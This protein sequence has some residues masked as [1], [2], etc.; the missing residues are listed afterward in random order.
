MRWEEF[1][2][3]GVV[4]PRWI[5]NTRLWWTRQS[6]H[7][8]EVRVADVEGTVLHTVTFSAITSAVS[9]ELA[10][11]VD[12]DHVVLS[13]LAVTLDPLSLTFDLAGRSWAYDPAT[14]TVAERPTGAVAGLD[15]SPDGTQAVLLREHD[16]WLRDMD[17]GV[18]RRLTR[19]GSSTYS[20][21]APCAARRE[22]ALPD[23]KPEGLWSPDSR[24]YFTLQADDRHVPELS[25][26]DFVPAAGGRP[27][28]LGN[29][30]SLPADPKV[31]EFR[32]LVLDVASGRQVEARHPRLS[33]VRMNDTV[34][35]GGMVWWSTDSNTAW[36]VDIERGERAAHVVAMDSTTGS[37]RTVMTER[38]DVPLEL[39]VNVYTPALICPLPETN[40]LVWYSE[41]SG[42]GHLYL[43][44]L[45]S[46]QWKR[47]IT[48]GEW[49]VRDVLGVD[50]ARREVALLAGGLD[51]SNPYLRRPCIASL[52]TDRLTVLS[53]TAGDHQV[54]R[55]R[56]F[57][58]I[59]AQL[60]EGV[61]VERVSGFSPDGE[62]FVETVGGI[63]ELP[64]TV[65]RRRDGAQVAVLEQAI[66]TGLPA[67][68][69]WPEPFTVKAADGQ[70]DLH[71]LLF[72]PPEHDPTTTYPII[73][74]IYGG[75]QINHTPVSGFMDP[76]TTGTL[77]E[78]AG[79]AQ[80]GGFA[81]I[82]DGRGTAM[83]DRAFRHHSLG[84]VQL[85]SDLADHELAIRTLAQREP[86]IDLAH[87]GMTGFSGGGYATAMA[88]FT[89]GDFFGVTVAGGGNYD[90]ALFWHG[91]GERYH[92]A[93]D[94]DLYAEQAAKTYAAGLQGKLMLIHG[95]LDSGCHP[96]GLFAV[97]Q[98]LVEANKD[99]DLVLLPQAAH[100]MPGYAVRRR[101]D[102]LVLHLFGG[103]P[104]RDISLAGPHDLLY[105]KL[106]QQR[107]AAE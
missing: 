1:V 42:R 100:A 76:I 51:A 14:D 85:A 31:T 63:G 93:F 44:D 10:R 21:G 38:A 78:A 68:F 49:Q 16:L 83:R 30:T 43:I 12:P 89:R 75:P 45:H 18:E 91:W 47:P 60:L 22:I 79:Y 92:G 56:E 23:A 87:V 97:L 81:V 39:S 24:R 107:L 95:L 62:S 19:D 52:D 88:A 34:F 77:C 2:A 11:E 53:E 5:G 69:A 94:A 50:P 104:P 28:V 99:V 32:L 66:P 102:H 64:S 84:A 54:W 15:V 98:A 29:R 71:G 105:E 65:L 106:T 20:Y 96:S 86:S 101:L 27:R 36:F 9:K 67:W 8:R 17:S 73:D 35:S 58:L 26:V 40:E 33:L 41:T 37:C 57:G 72:F 74:L 46:G 82:L 48:S 103:K 13:A 90:Q 80:L 70:T 55:P 4:L 3:N 61:D 59:A 7:G 6:E 25:Y